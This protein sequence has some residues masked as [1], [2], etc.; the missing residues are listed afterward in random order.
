MRCGA[1]EGHLHVLKW[2]REEGRL[3]WNNWGLGVMANAGLGGHLELMRWAR[4]DGCPLDPATLG[5][6]ALAGHLDVYKWAVEQGCTPYEDV[7]AR[8]AKG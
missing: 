1:R 4:A 3:S 6:A 2:A 8:A 7:L 5:N